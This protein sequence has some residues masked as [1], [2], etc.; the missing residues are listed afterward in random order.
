M[1]NPLKHPAVNVPITFERAA[2]NHFSGTRTDVS[3]V[4]L[5]DAKFL[6]GLC[7]LIA[8]LMNTDSIKGSQIVVLTTDPSITSS[9][10]IKAVNAKVV[11]IDD[12]DIASF[13]RISTANVKRG[14]RHHLV[15]K[16]T[17]LKFL[18]FKR[19]APGAQLFMDCDMI[20]LSNID[21]VLHGLRDYEFLATHTAFM[22]ADI[23]QMESELCDD[24][25]PLKSPINSGFMVIGSKVLDD[26]KRNV[27]GKLI[28]SAER[29][30][31]KKEQAI[32]GDYFL[33]TKNSGAVSIAYNFH[34]KLA[35]NV[36]ESGF[37]RLIPRI[38][39][40][41]YTGKKPWNKDENDYFDI[42]WIKVIENAEKAFGTTWQVVL[43]DAERMSKS[44][45]NQT[46][47]E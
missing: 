46:A 24:S 5:L 27:I 39:V 28:R 32:T 29:S 20:C 12:S 36:G 15:A 13:S 8:S 26:E 47:S 2:R 31:F 18:M 9:L 4:L 42:P 41:H 16:Y 40:L 34:R 19:L 38:K 14:E 45:I 33:R 17:L 11:T 7:T 30:K 6:P 1:S 3:L 43:T 44:P 10:I 35:N 37:N 21:S 23:C 25:L 22:S